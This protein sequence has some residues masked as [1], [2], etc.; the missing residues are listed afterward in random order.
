V[1]AR[2]HPDLGSDDIDR[3]RG[4]GLLRSALPVLRL[5]AARQGAARNRAQPHGRA[6]DGHPAGARRHDRLSGGLG[7]GGSLGHT[8]RARKHHLLRFRLSARAEGLR[9][10]HHR[11]PHQLSGDRDR[12]D[13]CR[14]SRKLRILPEQRPE[15][16][17]R[18]L[19][20]DTGAALALLHFPAYRRGHGR[21]S[22]LQVRLVA[23]AAVL[24]VAVAPL[25]LDPFSVTLANYIGIYALVALGLV[26][27]TGVGG[28]V[29]F[30]QAS[31]MG[32]AAYSTAWASAL[33]DYSPW[34]GLL[35][36]LVLT[37]L[38][39][40]ILGAVTL[41]LQGHFLSLSTIAWGLAIYFL[42]GN[43]D[44]LGHF[45]GIPSIPP[46]TIG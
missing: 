27:I 33:M 32:I 15:G 38:V 42:F 18:L 25:F 8:D 36:A 41:R 10:R 23:I 3:I 30:G 37:G 46:I 20:P 35:L 11:R 39:A 17:N 9:G 4:R 40:T 22:R 1:H 13:L 16:G 7:A 5:H 2:Q 43:V 34:F 31:F 26:L 24:L 45:N 6:A 44:G 19:D 14:A 28:M 21:M 12:F 29:S